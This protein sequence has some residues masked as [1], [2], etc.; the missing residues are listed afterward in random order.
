MFAAKGT[1]RYL[2]I[3]NGTEPVSNVVRIPDTVKMLPITYDKK[4]SDSLKWVQL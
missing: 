3:Q 4:D 1:G 2:Y